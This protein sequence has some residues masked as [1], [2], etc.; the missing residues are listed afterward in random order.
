MASLFTIRDAHP[1]DL[2]AAAVLAARLVRQHAAEDPQ[3]FAVLSEQLEAG[4]AQFLASR[5][6]HA[7]AVVLVAELTPPADNASAGDDAPRIA[8]Y[9]YGQVESP[10]WNELLDTAGWV[11]DLFVDENA[12][13]M[14]VGAALLEAGLARLKALGAPRVVLKTSWHNTP[15]RTLFT[16]LGFRPTMVEMTREV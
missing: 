3:R 15:A 14:G 6:R 8:G 16:K 10:N 13:G 9:L 2:P 7:Q 5:L 11:H 1:T 12:R 4:Y